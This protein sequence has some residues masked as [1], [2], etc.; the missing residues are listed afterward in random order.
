MKETRPLPNPFRLT[1]TAGLQ[2]ELEEKSIFFPDFLARI[3][4][5]Y[6]DQPDTCFDGGNDKY[7]FTVRFD[8]L[9][10]KLFACAN[11][12]GGITVMFP[13]EY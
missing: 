12:V 4:K 10:G 7:F 13:S 11:E 2:A 5:T 3:I 1:V 9:G 6:K 8:Q